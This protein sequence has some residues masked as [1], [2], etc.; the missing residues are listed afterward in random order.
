MFQA[1]RLMAVLVAVTFSI[2]SPGAIVFAQELAA[3]P[4]AAP[5]EQEMRQIAA[6]PKDGPFDLTMRVYWPKAEA[7]DGSWEPPPVERGEPL[8]GQN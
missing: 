5:S 2:A 7:L 6:A 4:A 1:H 3:R 8:S